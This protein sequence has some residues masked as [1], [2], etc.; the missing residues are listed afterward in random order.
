MAR[1]Q[2]EHFLSLKAGECRLRDAFDGGIYVGF[3]VND[4]GVPCRPFSKI[5]RLIQICPFCGAA[6]LFMNAET[7]VA[8]SGESDEARFRML[9]DSVAIKL[10]LCAGTEIHYTDLRMPG[11]F[12]NFH[13]FCGDR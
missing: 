9:D 1:E 2:A 8:R 7:D 4:D 11:F 13:K 5:V 3:G 6:A 10:E 12:Q